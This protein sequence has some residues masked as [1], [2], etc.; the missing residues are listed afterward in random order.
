V[1][2]QRSKQSLT[3]DVCSVVPTTIH[4]NQP[5]DMLCK[6]SQSVV[7]AV[8]YIDSPPLVSMLYQTIHAENLE[9]FE[10]LQISDF[11]FVIQHL[12]SFSCF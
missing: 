6:T 4:G 8:T 3:A 7:S 1:I 11:V 9:P 5:N 12:N 2:H 10:I